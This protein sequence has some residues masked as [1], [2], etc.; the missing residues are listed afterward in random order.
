MAEPIKG[1]KPTQ[2]TGWLGHGEHGVTV[3][4]RKSRSL[5]LA[6]Q[7]DA[8]VQTLTQALRWFR[9]LSVD[10]YQH[11]F[12]AI[13]VDGFKDLTLRLEELIERQKGAAS[14]PVSKKTVR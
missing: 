3:D 4:I 9:R 14:C 8:D 6:E 13:E 11:D 12:H 5:S 10:G 2:V 7:S 1:R